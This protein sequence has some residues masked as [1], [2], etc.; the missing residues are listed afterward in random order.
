MGPHDN[1]FA[2]GSFAGKIGDAET[3]DP[4]IQK[5]TVG[6]AVQFGHRPV[7]DAA[8]ADCG[9]D[10]VLHAEQPVKEPLA[11]RGGAVDVSHDTQ[12][13]SFKPQRHWCAVGDNMGHMLQMHNWAE[14]QCCHAAFA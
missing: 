7:I 5:F 11:G 4:K 12:A 1:S 9:Q 2:I 10:A 3:A 13:S 6:K 14:P 8:L